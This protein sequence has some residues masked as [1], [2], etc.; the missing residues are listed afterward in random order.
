MRRFGA[1]AA[2]VLAALALAACGESPED[3][4]RED[5]EQIGEQLRALF[6][7]TSA[8]EAQAALEELGAAAE[9]LEEDTRDHVGAQV[10]TQRT[11]LE[12]AIAELASGDVDGAKAAAQQ[13]RAQADSF[14][15]GNDSISNEFW[16]GFEEGYDG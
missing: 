10:D 6:D 15:S 1:I 11:T 8:E 4:A 3:E 5:G 13:I 7:A 2:A 14:R 9:E 12:T 16:R